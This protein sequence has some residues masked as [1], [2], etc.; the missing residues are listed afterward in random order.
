MLAVGRR[1][2]SG[3]GVGGMNFV[4]RFPTLDHLLPQQGTILKVQAMNLERHRLAWRFCSRE[5]AHRGDSAA[6][7]FGTADFL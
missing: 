6:E 1:G 7:S 3:V 4:L 2:F 5:T